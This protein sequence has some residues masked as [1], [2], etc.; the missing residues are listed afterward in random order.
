MVGVY[1][2]FYEFFVR[3][4]GGLMRLVFYSGVYLAMYVEGECEN[5]F[6]VLVVFWPF[7][8]PVVAY[9]L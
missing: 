3:C 7:K 5:W 6:Y 8:H 4:F 9:G 1:V 2:N